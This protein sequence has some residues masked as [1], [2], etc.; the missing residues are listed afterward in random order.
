[1]HDEDNSLRLWIRN[2]S[3]KQWKAYGDKKLF[4]KGNEQ[5][6]ALMEECL[7]ASVDEV[8]KAFT[9]KQVPPSDAFAA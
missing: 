5:N 4:E 9:T 3:G 2:R 7:Q 6:K 1:M 8:Y